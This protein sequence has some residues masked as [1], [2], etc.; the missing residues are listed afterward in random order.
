MIVRLFSP[1]GRFF[2]VWAESW[3]AARLSLRSRSHPSGCCEDASRRPSAGRPRRDMTRRSP[4][5]HPHV[6]LS[7]ALSVAR[8]AEMS[9]RSRKARR[10]RQLQKKQ[11]SLL[12]L[13]RV[14]GLEPGVLGH[15]S[16]TS[17]DDPQQAPA[18]PRPDAVGGDW[19]DRSVPAPPRRTFDLVLRNKTEPELAA[20]GGPV[21]RL[22]SLAADVVAR[23][24][25]AYDQTI[26]NDGPEGLSI[27]LARHVVLAL[28]SG[29]RSLDRAS[30]VAFVGGYGPAVLPPGTSSSD[31]PGRRARVATD[32]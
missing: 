21:R 25:D 29:H 31:E 15:A 3:D 26:W 30:W 8:T 27:E 7:A 6:N 2:C 10:E 9:L 17:D 12:W 13:L 20:T 22:T 24:L 5:R 4:R 1:L 18:P 16:P 14:R 19:S 28:Q 23:H 32:L 11:A